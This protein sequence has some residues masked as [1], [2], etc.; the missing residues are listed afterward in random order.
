MLHPHENAILTCDF[1]IL[2]NGDSCITIV[3]PAFAGIQELGDCVTM[4]RIAG[5]RY[6]SAIQSSE[7]SI[8]SRTCKGRKYSTKSNPT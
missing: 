6:E 8:E 2:T 5:S 3:M 4:S 7:N 1:V